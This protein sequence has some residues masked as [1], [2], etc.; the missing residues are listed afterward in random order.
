MSHKKKKTSDAVTILHQRY[1]KGDAK[2]LD[3]IEA[4]RERIQIAQQIYDMRQER[5]LTQKQ[6]AEIMGTTQSVISRLEN[7]DYESER[8]ET[9]HKIAA[10]LECHLEVRFVPKSESTSTIQD[11]VE[12]S[13][14]NI[15]FPDCN[16]S[17]ASTDWEPQES[18]TCKFRRYG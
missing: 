5:G 1:I 16:S 4:E 6:L 10:A 3:A 11:E 7:T 9:L 14:P 8:L 18:S 15:W 17:N 12:N 2:R 13:N